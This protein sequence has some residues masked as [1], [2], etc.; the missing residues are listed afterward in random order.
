MAN[1][2]RP[3]QTYPLADMLERLGEE[4]REAFQRTQQK[5]KASIGL[6]EA[7]IDLA[8]TWTAD[9]KGRL[10]IQVFQMGGGVSTETVQRMSITV[11]PLQHSKAGVD[12]V[13][14]AMD[15]GTGHQNMPV[16]KK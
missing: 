5:G 6:K 14:Q 4:L 3:V 15:F 8:W 12:L 7:V 13:A 1:Q 2:Q 16:G 10:N 11:V 9:A